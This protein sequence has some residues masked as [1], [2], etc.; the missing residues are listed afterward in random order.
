[1]QPSQTGSQSCNSISIQISSQWIRTMNPSVWF[2]PILRIRPKK[3]SLK[4]SGVLL[5]ILGVNKIKKTRHEN[6]W[7]LAANHVVM[8]NPEKLNQLRWFNQNLVAI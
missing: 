5:K 8:G 4:N 7:G 3:L 2:T 6:M 1:M